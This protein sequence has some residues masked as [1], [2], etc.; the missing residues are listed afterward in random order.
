[1]S[2]ESQKKPNL[3]MTIFSGIIVLSA[4]VIMLPDLLNYFS[5]L[6]R[7]ALYILLVLV[8][9]FVLVFSWRKIARLRD[10][11]R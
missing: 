6:G 7:V 2:E 4:I 11:K 1:M 3:W 8:L 10:D 5:G 9:T